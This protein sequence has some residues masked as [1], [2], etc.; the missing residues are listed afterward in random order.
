MNRTSYVVAC[1][2]FLL[3]ACGPSAEPSPVETLRRLAA[4]PGLSE[5][6]RGMLADGFLTFAEFERAVRGFVSCLV[7]Q[8]Y[9]AE[10]VEIDEQDGFTVTVAWP[11]GID[12]ARSQAER[13]ACESEYISA[14]ELAFAATRDSDSAD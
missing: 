9:V 12:R 7:A 5:F 10:S 4:Q 8:G 13:D 2:L 3:A 6:Q 11:E 1:F 14:V